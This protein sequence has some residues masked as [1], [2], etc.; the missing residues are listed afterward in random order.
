MGQRAYSLQFE[1]G[2]L[3]VIVVPM[4]EDWKFVPVDTV[5]SRLSREYG[6]P[7]KRLTY[8]TAN[9]RTEEAISWNRKGHQ[10]MVGIRCPTTPGTGVC[11]R[12]YHL[13]P[14]D[15]RPDGP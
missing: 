13:L 9:G 8:S 15:A 7:I 3:H 11:V 12:K 2:S 10:A 1:Q 6:K 14:P 4:D 5:V